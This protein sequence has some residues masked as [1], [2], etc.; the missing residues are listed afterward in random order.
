M[1]RRIIM[2]NTYKDNKDFVKEN[3]LKELGKPKKT[4]GRKKTSLKQEI[5]EQMIMDHYGI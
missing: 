3:K 2:G 1:D 5:N 4:K